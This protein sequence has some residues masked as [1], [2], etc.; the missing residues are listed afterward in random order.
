MQSTSCIQWFAT[1]CTI[2]CS[3]DLILLIG[4][5]KTNV[6]MH[7]GSTVD[8]NL[9]LHRIGPD[10]QWMKILPLVFDVEWMVS[11]VLMPPF[12]SHGYE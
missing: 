9:V 8:M 2:C 11:K 4:H 12:A 5:S 7:A 1:V 6:L 10:N 3:I